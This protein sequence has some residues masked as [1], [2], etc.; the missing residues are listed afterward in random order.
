MRQAGLDRQLRRLIINLASLHREDLEA[1]LG[2]LDAGQ[3]TTVERLL[4]EFVGFGFADE[5]SD[6]A[7]APAY[8]RSRISAWMLQRLESD[9][10]AITPQAREVLRECAK[11]VCEVPLFPAAAA[12]QT[13]TIVSEPMA[14]LIGKA[15]A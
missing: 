4:R 3:H 1:I 13:N 5:K 7:A 6:L 11:R 14:V 2:E 8:D 12:A 9:A 15:A 10:V